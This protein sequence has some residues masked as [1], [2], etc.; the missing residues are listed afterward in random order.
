MKQWEQILITIMVE[1]EWTIRS[2]VAQEALK[3][4]PLIE[5]FF[6]KLDKEGCESGM[7]RSLLEYNIVYWFFNE[8]YRE[9]S[10]TLLEY[11]DEDEWFNW[12]IKRKVVWLA[13]EKI[14]KEMAINDL[15]IAI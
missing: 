4:K 3:R 9:I 6:R 2:F 7:I 15:G 1:E 14:A 12:L 11:T 5:L 10:N 13:V 8:H